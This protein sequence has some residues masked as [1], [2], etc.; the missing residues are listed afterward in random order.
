MFFVHVGRPVPQPPL[1]EGL[2]WSEDPLDSLRAAF[3]VRD[4]ESFALSPWP[5]TVDLDG[6]GPAKQDP[7]DDYGREHGD[8]ARG[9]ADDHG[10][11][12]VCDDQD[13]EAQ[14]D[15]PTEML[16]EVLIRVRAFDVAEIENARMYAYRKAAQNQDDYAHAFD[17]LDDIVDIVVETHRRS[18]ELYQPISGLMIHH[19]IGGS[20]TCAMG[21]GIWFCKVAG[22][23][24]RVSSARAVAPERLNPSRHRCP[25]AGG[26]L[27]RVGLGRSHHRM[28][29]PVGTSSIARD[30]LS[31]R[32]HGSLAMIRRVWRDRSSSGATQSRGHRGR[33]PRAGS[34]LTGHSPT[35]F[36]RR[37][38]PR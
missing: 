38:Y 36:R 24:H 32:V 18:L 9:L 22:M 2:A 31:I 3:V 7:N 1:A 33:P 5:D 21:K 11:D 35:H 26:A 13:F 23:T 12:D 28:G 34:T 16:S 30:C 10:P 19:R 4:C 15:D 17:D 14:Q 37:P 25:D 29:L 6:E 27:L 8:A 20:G